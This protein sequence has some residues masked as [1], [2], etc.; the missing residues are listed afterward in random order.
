MTSTKA[1]PAQ[2]AA[3]RV[4]GSD[5]PTGRS[6]LKIRA[7]LSAC[8]A[9]GSELS[10]C[11]GWPKLPATTTTPG[12]SALSSKGLTIGWGLPGEA[13]GLAMRADLASASPMIGK[14]I[15]LLA[16]DHDGEV[17]AAARA[18]GRMLASKGRDWHDLAAAISGASQNG[19]SPSWTSRQ[20]RLDILDRLLASK[21]LSGW[22]RAFCEKT[23]AWLRLRPGSQLSSEAARDPRSTHCGTH[24]MR[25]PSMRAG[26]LKPRPSTWPNSSPSPASM[27]S[28]RRATLRSATTLASA[29]LPGSLSL[30]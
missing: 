3:G 27:R 9:T 6:T 1:N 28:R 26:R 29:T 30:M 10:P 13:R 21:A 12:R 23:N 18:I 8:N 2:R 22:E 4:Q 7:T 11:C 15:P 5:R 19:A 20:Q 14:L 24:L 25:P 16:S 17:L